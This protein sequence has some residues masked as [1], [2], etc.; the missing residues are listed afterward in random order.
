M[1]EEI[2]NAAPKKAVKKAAPKKAVKKA[3]DPK[4][5]ARGYN[6]DED[7]TIVVGGGDTKV[8]M[9]QSVGY[10]GAIALSAKAKAV[11]PAK[12]AERYEE[13]GFAKIED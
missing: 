1:S 5:I 10:R 13:L 8:T 12:I 6:V 3:A 4:T 11:L 7:G 9:L 2:N